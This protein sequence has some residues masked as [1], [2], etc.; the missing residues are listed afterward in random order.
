[1]QNTLHHLACRKSRGPR[2]EQWH[3]TKQPLLLLSVREDSTKELC[4]NHFCLWHYYMYDGHREAVGVGVGGAMQLSAW[5]EDTPL[6]CTRV[7]S[8][9]T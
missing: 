3:E 2:D 1:M 5:S 9:A 6:I 8:V 7:Q 4:C